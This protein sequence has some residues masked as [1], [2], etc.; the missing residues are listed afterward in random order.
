MSSQ[1][2]FNWIISSEKLDP[3]SAGL[4]ASAVHVQGEASGEHL[5][6][7]KNSQSDSEQTKATES[8]IKAPSVKSSLLYTE[9]SG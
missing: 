7:L 6:I 8:L 3:A 4:D 1:T 9:V 2:A 5:L